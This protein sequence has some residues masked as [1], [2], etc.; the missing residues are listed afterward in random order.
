MRRLAGAPRDRGQAVVRGL[1]GG[2]ALVALGALA[3][4]ATRSDGGDGLAALGNASLLLGMATLGLSAALGG[5]RVSR[6]GSYGRG[7]ARTAPGPERGLLRLSLA[8][9]GG[10]PF[11]LFVVLAATR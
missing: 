5:P 11:V 10:V 4:L 9:A 1:L 7:G 6:W 3:A 2:A 8:I